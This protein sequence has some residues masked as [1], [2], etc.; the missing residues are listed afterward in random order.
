MADAG[1]TVI[2]VES[3]AT[4]VP[5]LGESIP[6]AIF[7]VVVLAFLTAVNVIGVK[8]G[9]R[10]YV[11]NTWAKLYRW[12]YRLCHRAVSRMDAQS[13]AHSSSR[14]SRSGSTATPC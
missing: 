5:I 14:V 9:V 13:V 8:A 7:I 4:V 2:M 11:F 3:I 6:R 1:I 12:C 10:L